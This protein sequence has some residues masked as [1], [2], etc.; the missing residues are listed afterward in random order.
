[1]KYEILRSNHLVLG[2]RRFDTEIDASLLLQCSIPIFFVM[3]VCFV[4]AALLVYMLD[5]QAT[6]SEAAIAVV[7][8]LSNF[9]TVISFLLTIWFLA[10]HIMNYLVKRNVETHETLEGEVCWKQLHKN[11]GEWKSILITLP[12]ENILSNRKLDLSKKTESLPLTPQ[13]WRLAVPEWK[14]NSKNENENG[15]S[16]AVCIEV[17]T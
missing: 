3:L 5:N 10:Y 6:V 2:R 1:M 4:S 17:G 14:E 13:K 11:L 7:D 8:V 16:S 12:H 9:R 15:Q